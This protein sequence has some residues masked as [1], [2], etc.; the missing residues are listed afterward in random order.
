MARRFEAKRATIDSQLRSNLRRMHADALKVEEGLT[1]A[2]MLVAFRRAG[3]WYTFECDKWPHPDDNYRAIQLTIDY[4]WR[5]LEHYGVTREEA[6]AAPIQQRKDMYRRHDEAFDQLF[7]PFTATPDA[8]PLLIGDGR[9][10]WWEV[11][12]LPRDASPHRIRQ[13]YR[14]LI[15]L[16]HPD[17]EGGDLETAKRINAAYTAGMRERGAA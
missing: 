3:R 17:V 11:L 10:P 2:R 6:D 15:A 9:A 4:L 8:L 14:A 13:A 1:G 16:Q 7:L 12:G 5:A